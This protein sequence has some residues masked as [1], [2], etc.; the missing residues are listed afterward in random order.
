MACPASRA[1]SAQINETDVNNMLRDPAQLHMVFQPQVNLETGEVVAAEALA[2]WFH[3]T[4]GMVPPGC[5][6]PKISALG[7]QDALFRRVVQLTLEAATKLDIV[8]YSVP[9]AINACAAALS[10]DN[11]LSF[12]FEA[13]RQHHIAVSRL[14]IELTEHVPVS[15]IPLLR[16]ALL[17]LQDWGCT[18]CMDDFGAGHA[19]LGTLISLGFD[20][21]KLDSAF[22]ANVVTSHVAQRSVQFAVQLAGEMGWRVVAEGISTQSELNALYALGC[23]YGQGYLL[24]RPMSLGCLIAQP[25]MRRDDVPR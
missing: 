5:F 25:G 12:L 20:E 11:N 24:G 8:G 13:A 21:L 14:K 3:P 17:R 15:N 6:I 1:S 10:N 16:T 19:N 22:A 7:L 9:L 23:R 2:R 18:V 4:L